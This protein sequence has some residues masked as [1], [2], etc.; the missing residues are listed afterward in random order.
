ML[1]SNPVARPSIALPKSHINTSSYMASPLA[2]Q[3]ILRRSETPKSVRR[4]ESH[5]FDEEV[6][7]YIQPNIIP[8]TS[9]LLPPSTPPPTP[10]VFRLKSA[11]RM[12]SPQPYIFLTSVAAQKQSRCFTCETP[13]YPGGLRNRYARLGV[14]V[15][16]RG[17]V[18]VKLT[19]RKLDP[20]MIHPIF[21]S[22][23]ASV[24]G[25]ISIFDLPLCN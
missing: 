9:I 20:G 16:S 23:L 18:N 24:G 7:R 12:K 8:S 4:A 14:A 11:Q 19:I 17:P 2:Y 5:S 10:F 22:A 13:K 6:A 1:T 25:M 21:P 3:S 15:S